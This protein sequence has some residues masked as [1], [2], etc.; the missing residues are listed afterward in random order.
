LG[1]LK[2]NPLMVALPQD[3]RQGR[4]TELNAHDV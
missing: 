3:F 1:G 4:C 2:D